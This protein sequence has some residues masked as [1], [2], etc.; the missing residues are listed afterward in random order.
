MKWRILLW[1][2]ALLYGVV[3]RIRNVLFDIGIIKPRFFDI[4]II[5]VGN[6][7]TGGTGKTPHVEYIIKLMAGQMKLAV[8]S[9]GYGRKSKGFIEIKTADDPSVAGDEPLQFKKKFSDVTVA[10]CE[11]RVEGIQKLIKN[12]N[13]EV[14]LLD[15]AFQHR[16]VQPSCS[17]LLTAYSSPFYNDYLLPAGN[18]REPASGKKRASVVVVTKC[19]EEISL[20]ERKSIVEKLDIDAKQPVFFSFIRY[21]ELI[22][23]SGKKINELSSKKATTVLLVCGIADPQLLIRRLK[24][25]FSN[26]T[27]MIFT[28]HYDYKPD[29]ILSIERKFNNIAE[30]NK[31]IVT[32]EKDYIRL[33]GTDVSHLPFYYLPIEI[34][35]IKNDKQSFNQFI[36]DHVRKNKTNS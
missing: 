23:F 20:E 25:E 28:D 26:V 15:D 36:I 30:G 21:A 27:E 4:P 5:S 32:T 22:S 3:I 33:S 17:I 29:D 35:F 31:I 1:P 18:L 13:T 7:S 24:S 9:R 14:I 6:L 11:K 12:Q 34:D 2:F 8:L 16:Y 10:V 19:P